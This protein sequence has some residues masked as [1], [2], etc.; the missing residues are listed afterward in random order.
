MISEIFH[1]L[2]QQRRKLLTVVRN[3]KFLQAMQK[4]S[5]QLLKWEEEVDFAVK[6]L[7]QL[8][9]GIGEELQALKAE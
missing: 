7:C 8:S 4:Q 6:L 9:A 3:G 2:Y 5:S 1:L